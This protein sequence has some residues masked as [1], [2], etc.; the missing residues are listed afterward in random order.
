MML[1]FFMLGRV[2]YFAEYQ[3]NNYL[4]LLPSAAG[5]D[6]Y[7]TE[8]QDFKCERSVDV[9]V[10]GRPHAYM[11]TALPAAVLEKGPKRGREADK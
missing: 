2:T 1:S 8:R 6:A 7:V 11:P 9:A 10:C 5:V 4:C 3:C